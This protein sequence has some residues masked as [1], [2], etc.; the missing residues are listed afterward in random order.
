MSTVPIPLFSY[1]PGADVVTF[2]PTYP[3]TKKP[4]PQDG[5]S[6]ELEVQRV[7]SITM[8]GK[9]QVFF[10]RTD[11]FRVLEFTYVPF[12]DYVN[13]A[14]F[15]AWAVSGGQFDYY[16]DATLPSFTT[17]TLEDTSWKPKFSFIGVS[18][19][20]MNMRLLV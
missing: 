11:T 4:G 12:P 2:S 1:N 9:K 8:S 5:T 10:I 3:P 20:T 17:Y 15:M 16:P 7:D 13:W 19:F 6:D 14:P 18:S